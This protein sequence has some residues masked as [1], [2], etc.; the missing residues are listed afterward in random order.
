VLCGEAVAAMWVFARQSC[1]E[2]GLINET[3]REAYGSTGWYS[4]RNKLYVVL[5]LCWCT[6]GRTGELAVS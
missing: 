5:L 2:E 4:P 1:S 6:A 3:S